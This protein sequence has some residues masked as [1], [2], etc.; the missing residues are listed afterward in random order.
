[1]KIQFIRNALVLAFTLLDISLF[2][3]NEDHIQEGRYKPFYIMI[4]SPDSA[5]I[6]DSLI[7]LIDTVQLEY[8]KSYY[9][10]IQQME[11]WKHIEPE[12]SKWKT[13]QKIQRAKWIVSYKNIHSD[14]E[15]NKLNLKVTTVLYSNKDSRI[16]FEKET[17]GNTNKYVN[18]YG[19]LMDCENPLQCL[20]ET[21]ANSLTEELFKVLSKKHRK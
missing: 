14:K 12:E 19:E 9:S 10:H 8:I 13:E 3:Q 5:T 6:D 21:S 2:G 4:I 1:M 16:I 7:P 20:L 15:D 17:K 18:K 11:I